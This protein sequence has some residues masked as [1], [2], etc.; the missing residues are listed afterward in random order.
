MASTMDTMTKEKVATLT[1]IDIC[2]ANCPA[3]A[4]VKVTINDTALLFCGHHYARNEI[5]LA[6]L[7]SDIVDE[8]YLDEKES[9]KIPQNG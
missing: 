4:R 9:K 8:R 3:M 6:I 7:A 5:H 1:S 2:D